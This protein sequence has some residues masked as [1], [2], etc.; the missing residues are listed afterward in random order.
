[1]VT[2]SGIGTF[3]LERPHMRADAAET[4]LHFVG[5]HHGTGSARRG[6]GGGQVAFRQHDLAG[7]TRE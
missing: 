5:N 2:M 6:I 4:D 1:M 7:G 3:R